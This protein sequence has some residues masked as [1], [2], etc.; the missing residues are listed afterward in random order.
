MAGHTAMTWTPARAA[1]TGTTAPAPQRLPQA[2]AQPQTPTGPPTPTTSQLTHG[3]L[4]QLGATPPG[5]ATTASV[6][7]PQGATPTPA[8]MRA[9]RGAAPGAAAT[10]LAQGSTTV[11]T[12]STST[13]GVLSTRSG[14]AGSAGTTKATQQQAWR[15]RAASL[16]RRRLPTHRL[17]QARVVMA[18]AL[19]LP[20]VR[21]PWCKARRVGAT[22]G[23][24]RTAGPQSPASTGAPQGPAR[25]QG[26]VAGRAPGVGAPRAAGALPAM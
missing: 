4:Q 6:G 3:A 18:V 23:P 20:T 5:A 16:A 11:T 7:L 21:R 9:G 14:A 22:T 12:A 2:Q 19:L 15:G 13:G 10:L 26:G 17:L 1:A 24:L 25:L 8:A